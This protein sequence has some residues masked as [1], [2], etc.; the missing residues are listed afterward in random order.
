[1][2]KKAQSIIVLIFLL[3]FSAAAFNCKTEIAELQYSKRIIIINPSLGYTKSFIYLIENKIIDIPDTEFVGIIYDK[4]NHQYERTQ[5]YLDENNYPFYRIE[6]V[7]GNLKPET[8]FQQNSCSE[9]FH[10]IFSGS[11][12]ILF[13]GGPDVPSGI[14]GS[15]TNLLTNITDPHRHYFELSFLF[16][17]LGG[18]QN[19]SL[20]P[21]L[22]ED[23]N[24]IVNAFC[25]GLQTMNIATGGTLYQDIPSEVYGLKYVEDVLDMDKE[26]IHSGYKGRLY[27]G[28]GMNWCNFHRIKLIEDTFFVTEMDLN[29]GDLPY[30][31]SAHHQAIKDVGKNLKI[32]AVSMDGKIIEALEHTEYENVFSVQ[33]HPEFSDLYDPEGDK[34]KNDPDDT[35]EFTFNELLI[36]NKAMEFHR[37]YWEYFSSLFAR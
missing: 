23:K 18:N 26:N 34:F 19:E 31:L 21:L 25:L 1:M 24:Y 15:K 29:P 7:T 5:E 8:L 3:I 16:H 6:K 37:K 28:E 35:D 27:P 4:A 12:G 33:F 30:V 36:E 2:K 32:A 20:T 14:F 13:L 10:R 9:D 17:L 22:E 11:D